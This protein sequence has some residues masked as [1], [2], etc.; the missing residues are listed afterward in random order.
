MR[1]LKIKF[2]F[3]HG[4]L[5]KDQ[6]DIDTGKWST[7]IEVIDDDKALN[8]LNEEAQKEYSALYSFKDGLLV[9]DDEAYKKKKRELL[10]LI[11]TIVLRVNSL[12]DGTYEVIDEETPKLTN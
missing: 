2:D 5:W 10:S 7:G 4:P 3:S 1:Q 6:Y 11:Q 12:N 9:F 8:I